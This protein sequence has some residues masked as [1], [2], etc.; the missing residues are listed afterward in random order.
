MD[1]KINEAEISKEKNLTPK[2]KD[3]VEFDENRPLLIEAG[4]GTGKTFVL[5]EKIK[6]LLK[7]GEDPSSFL[8]I[9]FTI[10]AA[11]ELKNKLLIDEIGLKDVNK[12]QIST[13]HSFC[14][15]LLEGSEKANYKIFS[16]DNNEKKKIFLKNHLKELGFVNEYYAT[17]GQLNAIISKYDEYSAF[18]VDTEPLIKYIE[19]RIEQDESFDKYIDF[20]KR[21]ISVTGFFPYKKI[22]VNGNKK[23]FK[24]IK[25]SWYNARYL[26]AAKSY[27]DYLKLLEDNHIT[28]FNF[29]QFDAV[30]LLKKNPDDPYENISSG[31]YTNILIDEF[32]DTDPLQYEL[33]KIL[34]HEA[35]KRGGSF[36]GV[37]DANQRIYG[38]RGSLTNY[39]EVM[40]EEFK[41]SIEVIRLD[42]NHRSTNEIIRLSES[43]INHQKDEDNLNELKGYRNESKDSFYIANPSNEFEAGQIGEIIKFLIENQG[44]NYE[45][46]AIL[47]RSVKT[48]GVKKLVDTFDSMGIPC[49]IKGFNDLEDKDEIQSILFLLNYLVED[50]RKITVFEPFDIRGFIGCEFEQVFV[51]LSDETRR[52]IN[53]LQVEFEDSAIE[54]DDILRKD[55]KNSRSQNSITNIYKRREDIY[56]KKLASFIERPILSN[57]NLIKEGVTNEEDLEFFKKLNALKELVLDM[58]KNF[59]LDDKLRMKRIRELFKVKYGLNEIPTI[60]D[61]FYRILEI[62]N[63][64]TPEFLNNPENHDKIENIAL[65]TSTILNYENIVSEYDVPG[66]YRFLNSNI[67]DYGTENKEE[68]GVQVMTVHKSKGLEFPVVFVLS[69]EKPVGNKTGFPKIFINPKENDYIHGKETFYTPSE[70]LEYKNL[71]IEEEEKA[72]DREEERIIYVAMTRAQDMLIL[73]CIEGNETKPEIIQNLIDDNSDYIKLLDDFDSIPKI[74]KRR[75]KIDDEKIRLSYTTISNF[76]NCPL[77]FRMLNDFGFNLSENKNMAFGSIAHQAFDEINKIAK[78]REISAEEIDDIIDSCFERSFDDIY[79][80]KSI[81]TIKDAIYYYWD[82]HRPMSILDSEYSFDI[83][84]D[85]EGYSLVG[86]VDLI[87]ETENGNLGLIDYKVSKNIEDKIDDYEKQL[88]IYKLAL[89]TIKDGEYS[90]R[91]IEE[92]NVYSVLGNE[93]IPLNVYDDKSILL[94]E[95]K[96]V[97]EDIKNSKYENRISDK[98]KSCKF[99]FVCGVN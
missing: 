15:K 24:L 19:D 25:K 88:N 79:D 58:P 75:K 63:I 29:L 13:I 68:H 93:M 28:D 43:F 3:C 26:Q 65:I 18:K 72:Y 27:D 31:P 45:D 94:E 62:S 42:C 85:E 57:E 12:M 35:L 30:D 52:I 96:S 97:V 92:L 48:S 86:S 98:C 77:R 91:Q 4:P 17:G 90:G 40:K 78:E 22:S 66:L 83:E 21:E 87:Y 7:K 54:I 76:E 16:D 2:Q 73:S 37:G 56:L 8:V 47:S 69:L 38:F 59:E 89:D 70:F 1:L 11:E 80:E 5:I 74:D 60:L 82:N 84:N 53:K 71:S 50:E 95:I 9:T 23:D 33:F 34:M 44:L 39:F 81:E 41:D 46:I 36:T 55:I 32:Q 67:K 99:K 10:K 14:L 64:F 49:Q 61:V 51:G 20:I 6:H